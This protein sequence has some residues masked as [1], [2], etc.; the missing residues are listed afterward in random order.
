MESIGMILHIIPHEE[1]GG[2]PRQ[3]NKII[4]F[5]LHGA[6]VPYYFPQDF[7]H[8]EGSD[9]NPFGRIKP[10]LVFPDL[11]VDH[12]MLGIV[13][14]GTYRAKSLALAYMLAGLDRECL[15]IGVYRDIITVLHHYNVAEARGCRAVVDFD[16]VAF[17]YG[18]GC[19]A[20]GHMSVYSQILVHNVGQ[21]RR[22]GMLSKS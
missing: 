8:S 20:I 9:F 21:I 6:V 1:E 12:S 4:P 22:Y 19:G 7:T 18:T 2:I 15:Q 14:I 16:H 5:L 17:V 13:E 10:S 11:K 3:A